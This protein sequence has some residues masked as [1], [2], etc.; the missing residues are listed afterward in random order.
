LRAQRCSAILMKSQLPKLG[1]QRAV[2]D[3]CAQLQQRS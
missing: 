2:F 1:W 3:K